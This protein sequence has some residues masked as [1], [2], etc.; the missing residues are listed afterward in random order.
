VKHYTDD[1][2]RSGPLHEGW[3]AFIQRYAA[4]HPG[5]SEQQI[6]RVLNVKV[7]AVFDALYPPADGSDGQ[8]HD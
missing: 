4:G 1:V 3:Q 8:Q 7:R 2:P 6:A 5:D